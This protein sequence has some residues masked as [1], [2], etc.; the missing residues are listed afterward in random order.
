LQLPRVHL[1]S[2]LLLVVILAI[3]FTL[4]SQER[5]IAA[6]ERSID[7]REVQ[8]VIELGGSSAGGRPFEPTPLNTFKNDKPDL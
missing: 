5:R 1:K 4:V 7:E 3:A 2:L 6:L 8:R